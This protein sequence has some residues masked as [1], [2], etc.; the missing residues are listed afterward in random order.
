MEEELDR[1]KKT[2]MK[3]NKKWLSKWNIKLHECPNI[4][5]EIK[6]FVI[7]KFRTAMWTNHSE[8][9]KTYY[10]KEFNP[11]CDHGEEPYLEAAIKGKARLLVAQL[12][13]GSHHLRCETGRWRVPKEVW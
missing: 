6:T 5:E 4:K 3:Q 11:N 2:W 10:I 7:E 13:M 12:R 9:K 8:R 1:R